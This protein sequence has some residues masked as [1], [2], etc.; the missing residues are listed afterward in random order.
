MIE[1][2]QRLIDAN[3]AIEKCNKLLD[4]GFSCPNPAALEGI[5]VVRNLIL[6]ECE[7]GCPTVD[8]VEVVH[9]RW[10][11][12][13]HFDAFGSPNGAHYECSRCHYD[14]VYDIE[15]FYYCPNCGAKMDG[16]ETE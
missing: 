12:H 11:E 9:G 10:I 14:D 1:N 7:T 2:K 13:I 15:D 8:A 16:E 3:I 6:S 4:N 5:E